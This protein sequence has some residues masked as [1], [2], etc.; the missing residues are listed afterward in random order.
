MLL[1][2]L[3]TEA[4]MPQLLVQQQHLDKHQLPLPRLFLQLGRRRRFPRFLG[5]TSALSPARDGNF[6]AE[7]DGEGNVPAAAFVSRVTQACA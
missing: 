4:S 3:I 2:H 1:L 5:A 6:A 7:A